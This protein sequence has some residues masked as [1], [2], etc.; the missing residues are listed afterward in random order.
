M[1]VWVMMRLL[2][3]SGLLGLLRHKPGKRVSSWKRVVCCKERVSMEL[4][5]PGHCSCGAQ[6]A[7][8]T[9]ELR[10]HC[11]SC[12]MPMPALSFTLCLSKDVPHAFRAR[13]RGQQAVFWP[14]GQVLQVEGQ[15]VLQEPRSVSFQGSAKLSVQH[16]AGFPEA[17]SR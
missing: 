3:R 2:L 7:C 17:P 9:P 6:Q 4:N 14:L 5:G 1:P 16:T 12:D 11:D 15:V 13:S 8:A 10:C